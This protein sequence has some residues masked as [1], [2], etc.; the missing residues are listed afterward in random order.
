MDD[1]KVLHFRCRRGPEGRGAKRRRLDTLDTQST[2][3]SCW[4]GE[5]DLAVYSDNYLACASC[6]SLVSRVGL[7]EE[8]LRVTDDDVSYYGKE[9]WHSHQVNDFGFGDIHERIRQDLPQRCL[10]WLRSL[11]TFKLP[12][13]RVLE[14]GSAHGGFVALLRWTGFDALG[15]EISSWV[16][17]FA[18]STFDIPMLLGPVEEQQHLQPQSLDAIVLNDVLE[19]LPDPAGTIRR[20]VELLKP[21]GVL[22]VQT[23]C[24]VETQTHAELVA[25]QSPFLQ[26][27]GDKVA[28]EHIYVFSER[29]VRRL[30]EQAGCLTLVFEPALFPADMFFVASRSPV[31]RTVPEEVV[32]RLNSRPLGRLILALLDQEQHQSALRVSWRNAEADRVALGQT[33]GKLNEHIAGLSKDYDERLRVILGQ[34]ADLDRLRREMAERE[35]IIA[36]QKAELRRFKRIP[37][38]GQLRIFQVL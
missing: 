24:F 3:G 35:R 5:R 8:Q 28:R 21:D 36:A 27:I 1:Y 33:I 18:R 31:T 12:P 15:L 34:Q 23:P 30:F 9:Y 25:Q 13:A 38:L 20:C 37:L 16:V 11:L 17:D 22:L 10:S 4:C 6:G 19:H 2:R 26:M 7:S 14:L 29:S 32:E